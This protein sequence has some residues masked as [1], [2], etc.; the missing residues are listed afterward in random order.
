MF[1]TKKDTCQNMIELLHRRS[2]KSYGRMVHQKSQGKVK[3][4]GALVADIVT[5]TSL[6]LCISSANKVI[7]MQQFLCIFVFLR[8]SIFFFSNLVRGEDRA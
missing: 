5:F 3:R 6:F 1:R 7:S 2:F 8:I 4:K